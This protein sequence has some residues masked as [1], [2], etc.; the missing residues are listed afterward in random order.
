MEYG[1]ASSNYK[2]R[3]Y[4]NVFDSERIQIGLTASAR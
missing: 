1:A 4:L 3:V 2:E